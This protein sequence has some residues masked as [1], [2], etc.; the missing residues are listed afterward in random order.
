[1]EFKNDVQI[2]EPHRFLPPGR[3]EYTFDRPS[4]YLKIWSRQF[5]CL[6]SVALTYKFTK[7]WHNDGFGIYKFEGGCN[8]PGIGELVL[9]RDYCYLDYGGKNDLQTEN[10]CTDFI[11]ELVMKWDPN[12]PIPSLIEITAAQLNVDKAELEKHFVEKFQH[13]TAFEGDSLNSFFDTSPFEKQK[14]DRD[15][16][17]YCCKLS[18]QTD[19]EIDLKF[20]DKDLGDK[21]LDELN[22]VIR[23]KEK[24]RFE[25]YFLCCSPSRKGEELK[26]WLNDGKYYGWHSENDVRELIKQIRNRNRP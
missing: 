6:V 4:E 9:G 24:E 2:R 17:R 14:F 11:S 18:G 23:E 25:L 16:L 20:A 21:L 19:K 10:E 12:N 5:Q 15:Y 13:S 8:L 7:Q 22:N 3:K 26:F 1:M